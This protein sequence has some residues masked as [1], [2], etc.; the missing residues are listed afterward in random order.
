MRLHLAACLAA[1]TAL[2]ATAVADQP[3]EAAPGA[4]PASPLTVGA[5][6]GGYGFR[7][8]ASVDGTGHVAWDQCRM[9]GLG[10]FARRPLGR[11]FAEGGADVYF[12]ES[13]PTGGADVPA[14]EP[15]SRLSGLVTVAAGAN[16]VETKR[17]VAYA[18]LGAGVE[19]TQFRFT[20]GMDTLEDRRA[21][22]LGF[23]GVGG[24]LRFGRTSLGASLRAHVMGNYSA[25]Y[26]ADRD[27]WDPESNH[28]EVTA[29]A[30]AQGQFY[31]G[32]AL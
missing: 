17:F 30:A 15:R 24:E 27:T 9:N 23:V 21:L 2:T 7:N 28:L 5:R 1:T 13:F 18:Q 16:V 32:Y 12:T 19:V 8:P 6:V 3:T 22:P 14:G 25:V 4:R 29:E 20:S 10:V 26:Q 11:F 31:V